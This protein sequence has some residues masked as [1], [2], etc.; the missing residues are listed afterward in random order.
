MKPLV[1]ICIPTY[2]R[3]EQLR[4]TIESIMVQP[5]FREGKVEIVISDNASDD[6]TEQTGRQYASQSNHIIY[7][8]NEQNVRD[9]NFPLA[10]SRGTGILRKLNND[11]LCLNRDALKI[12]CNLAE[13]YQESRPCIF[14]SNGQEAGP[15]RER[16]SFREFVVT[17][18]HYVTWIGGFTIWEDDCVE[19]EK[20]TAG[21]E[22]SLWQVRKIYEMAYRKNDIV[23]CNRRI[24]KTMSPA[25]KDISY[26]LYQVFYVNFMKLLEPYEKNQSLHAEDM[27]TIQKNLLFCF[28]TDWMIKWELS[29]TDAQYSP[30]ENLKELVLKQYRDKTYWK[31]YQKVYRRRYYF[32]KIFNKLMEIK[33]FICRK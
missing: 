32:M 9:R 4:I 13:D 1:S 2:N 19:L 18:G 23:V 5:E 24:G 10:L 15:S 25:K 7:F 6:D 26:G 16:F 33:K 21:C 28:F 20:D 12:L 22:L 11:T 27:E 8:R 29:M 30:D 31:E 17:E 14:F 3:A